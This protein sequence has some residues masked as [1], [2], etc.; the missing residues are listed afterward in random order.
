MARLEHPRSQSVAGLPVACAQSMLVELMCKQEA[1]SVPR[2]ILA[3][4]TDHTLS[5]VPLDPSHQKPCRSTTATP[6]RPSFRLSSCTQPWPT[7]SWSTCAAWTLTHRPSL[8]ETPASSVP[9]VSAGAHALRASSDSELFSPQKTKCSTPGFWVLRRMLQRD[10][11][12]K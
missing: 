9:L 4:Q 10:S 11:Q 12:G 5:P 6:G 1:A 3:T 8:P 2:C 7:H